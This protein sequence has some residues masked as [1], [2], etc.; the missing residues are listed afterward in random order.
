MTVRLFLLSAHYREPLS[1]SEVGIRQ[2][3]AERQRLQDFIARL[4]SFRKTRQGSKSKLAQGFLRDFE[5]AM[6]DDLNTPKAFAALFTMVKEVNGLIDS[7]KLS[8][9]QATSLLEA[10]GMANSVLGFMRFEEDRLSQRLHNLIKK[11]EEARRKRDFAA[12]DQ[13]RQDLLKEGVALE[14]TPT[15]TVWRVHARQ[16]SDAG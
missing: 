16:A 5:R 12:A 4:R 13:I 15:G 10:L 3:D 1:Y 6:D 2:A 11:R 9:R 14:D 8:P 7:R